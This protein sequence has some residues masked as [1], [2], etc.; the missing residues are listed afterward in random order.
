MRLAERIRTWSLGLGAASIIIAG[1]AV[2][3]ASDSSQAPSGDLTGANAVL[4]H[5]L[6]ASSAQQGQPVEAKLRNSV[7]TDTG[8]KLDK[9]TLLKG[10]ITGLEKA[11]S[12][13]ASSVTVAFNQAQL[14]N[15]TVIPVKV[16]LLAAF[17]ASAADQA[18][19]GMGEVS[20]APQHVNPLTK[21][22]QEPGQLSHIS[23]H[24]SVQ[25]NDSG[26]FGDKDGNLKLRAGTYLQV[27]IAPAN[28]T[29]NARG[30]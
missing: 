5:A 25:S 13:G 1:A 28:G 3:H 17:P 8:L 12:G 29:N 10:T 15:G 11:S 16:T 26:T 2:A 22:D 24:S 14:K 7:K 18:T 6:D 30:E 21:I 20:S 4:V 19:Y 27:G 23:M 9:G